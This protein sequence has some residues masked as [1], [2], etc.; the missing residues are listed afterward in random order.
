MLPPLPPLPMQQALPAAAALCCPAV[1]A[2]AM[3][4]TAAGAAVAAAAD[5]VFAAAAA[6]SSSL[7]DKA[8]PVGRQTPSLQRRLL[9]AR[10][11]RATLHDS[12]AGWRQPPPECREESRRTVS[13][14]RLMTS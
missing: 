8:G 1:M 14:L 13:L 7:L 3:A 10:H 2:G 11:V 12:Q 4:S 5:V 6:A 9:E